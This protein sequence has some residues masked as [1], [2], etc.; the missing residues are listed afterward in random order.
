MVRT[1]KML[2]FFLHGV[3]TRHQTYTFTYIYIIIKEDSDHVLS[4][5]LTKDREIGDCKRFKTTA[6]TFI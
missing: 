4:G 1:L 6:T 2:T 3:S 5:I